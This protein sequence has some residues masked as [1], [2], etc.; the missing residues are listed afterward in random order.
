[1]D[2]DAQIPGQGHAP[3]STLAVRETGFLS[4]L[5]SLLPRL[6]YSAVLPSVFFER[7]ER[8][9]A[10]VPSFPRS[11]ASSVG[12][13][14]DSTGSA[15][16]R[17]ESSDLLLP[18]DQPETSTSGRNAQNTALTE[19]NAAA[20]A[21]RHRLGAGGSFDLQAIAL[22]VEKTAPF[23]LL[24]FVVFAY[25]HI[26]GLTVFTWISLV[27]YRANEALKKQVALK[28]DYSR[29]QCVS[30][31]AALMGHVLLVMLC[32]HQERLWLRFLLATPSPVPEFWTA[33]YWVTTVDLLV[34]HFGMATKL[35]VMTIWPCSTA[36]GFRRR[37]QA[38]AWVENLSHLYR[39]LLP[40]PVWYKFFEDSG[41]GMV[42]CALTT[43]IYLLV[44][45]GM[46]VELASL[47]LSSAKAVLW[48][49]AA[50]GQYAKPE[51]VM[52]S[53]NQCSICQDPMTDPIKLR[54]NHIFCDSCISEWFERERTC[55]M[56]RA[57]IKP[58]GLHAFG[59][60]TTSQLPQCF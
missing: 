3:T 32:L 47:L 17:G 51:E 57:V 39:G 16:F 7:Q 55:P 34:R 26:R 12:S 27:L 33:L 38:L 24:L 23:L 28:Q 31:A 50:Y 4:G 20:A 5:V 36:E 35:G 60:G 11:R 43:G 46:L 25:T 44:K 40:M 41:M 42:L 15:A 29:L 10:G 58:A 21:E 13:D 37:A 54:C 53:G 48:Q 30:L 14:D 19:D 6:G 18:A 45:C 8:P 52:E 22:W 59:D 56:C 9:L 2:T 1:M 49:E